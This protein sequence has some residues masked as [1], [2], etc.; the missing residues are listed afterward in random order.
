MKTKLRKLIKW[1]FLRYVW[2]AEVEGTEWSPEAQVKKITLE[3]AEILRGGFNIGMAIPNGGPM[4]EWIAVLCHTLLTIHDGKMPDNYRE[5]QL[6]LQPIR[7]KVECKEE[8]LCLTVQRLKGLTPHQARKMAEAQ[9]D[10]A[11]AELS[12]MKEA[13][14]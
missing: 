9:R 8:L 11:L 10:A 12:R 14:K 5:C 6:T 7:A 1:L 2:P 13:L 4:G 3:H